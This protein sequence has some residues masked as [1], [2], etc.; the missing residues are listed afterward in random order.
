MVSETIIDA[1]AYLPSQPHVLLTD[2]YA[3]LGASIVWLTVGTKLKAHSDGPIV[4]L[5]V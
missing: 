1:G 4:W 2:L 5:E 3:T